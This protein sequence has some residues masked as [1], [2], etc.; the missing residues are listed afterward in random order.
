[1]ICHV[2]CDIRPRSRHRRCRQTTMR[3]DVSTCHKKL[4][5]ASHRSFLETT[6]DYGIKD[7]IIEFLAGY[8]HVIPRGRIYPLTPTDPQRLKRNPL[9]HAPNP[10]QPIHSRSRGDCID[11]Q[12]DPLVSTDTAP[13]ITA[14]RFEC[15]SLAMVRITATDRMAFLPDVTLRFGNTSSRRSLFQSARQGSTP[16]SQC[17][18]SGK[19]D[20]DAKERLQHVASNWRVGQ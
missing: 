5:L 19:D 1:M 2:A 10:N 14:G 12:A 7:R 15:R 4:S 3:F 20:K 9:H 18:V 8:S 17:G 6:S 13:R 16:T 11:T